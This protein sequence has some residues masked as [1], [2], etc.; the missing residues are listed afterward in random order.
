MC[1][2]APVCVYVHVCVLRGGFGKRKAGEFDLSAFDEENSS[3]SEHKAFKTESG[4]HGCWK[5][6]KRRSQNAA[7][8]VQGSPQGKS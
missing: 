1:V 3:R 6:W 5:S 8:E 4:L 7:T 2:Y